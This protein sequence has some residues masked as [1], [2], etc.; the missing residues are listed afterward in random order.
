MDAQI[1][2]HFDF[3][4]FPLADLHAHISS[5]THP[6]VYWQ[7]AHDQG[8]KLPKKDYFE[9]VNYISLSS[10]KKMTL[11]EYLR[12]IMHPLLDKLGSGT[13]ALER[14]MYEIFIGAYRN[15]ISLLEIRNNPMRHNNN[16]EQDLDLII[17]SQL[18]GMERAIL[19]YPNL[20]AGIIFCLARE[21]DVEKNSIIVEKAIKYHK[22]GI[23]GI[24]IAGVNNKNFKIKD[25]KTIFKRAKKAGLKITV[26]SGEL[27]TDNDM[28]EALEFIT[29]QR[30]GHGIRAAYDKALM[31]ELAKRKVVLEICPMSNIATRAV[32]NIDEMKWIL[33]TF[34]ENEVLFTINTD[35]P[36]MIQN[37]HLWRVYKML[38]DE[39][40]MTETQLKKCN[41]TAF[42]STFI[43]RK[44]L[45]AY[46]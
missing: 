4:D 13:Y 46:L 45:E 44:G 40:I 23:V 25:Y 20:S 15:N 9:F 32:K 29:P 38:L 1:T 6:S 7:I 31:K 24:D 34:I 3:P 17:M 33:R 10:H 30:I 42:N 5:S 16:G 37:G 22:R 11:E 26:H 39:K 2:K 35:W 41:Q 28:W 19:E 8:I 18:R 21:F 43:P 14:S 36:E 12:K 27:I